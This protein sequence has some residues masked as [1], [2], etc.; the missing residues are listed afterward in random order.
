MSDSQT[1][2]DQAAYDVRC[3]WGLQAVKRL[4][5]ISDAVIIVDVFSFSTSVC[6]AV[7]RGAIVYPYAGPRAGL[8]DFAAARNAEVADRR[9][10]GS[11]YSLAPHSLLAIPPDTRLVLPSPNGSTLSTHTGHTPTLAG[12]LLNASAVAEAALRYG[13]HIAIVPAGER[14]RENDTMRPSFE[15]LIGAGAIASHLPGT[16]SPEVQAAVAAY[17]WA[18][19]DLLRLLRECGSGRELIDRGSGRDIDLAAELD[20][21]RC[22]PLLQAGAYQAA[23]KGIRP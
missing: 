17:Q 22:A 20:N 8:A 10:S 11:R 18:R 1:W 2:F 16:Q 19:H 15:D 12:C 23:A 21:S 6:I 9:E 4:A 3:E 13:R 7:E 5:P 14:W